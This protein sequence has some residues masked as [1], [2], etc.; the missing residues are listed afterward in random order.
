MLHKKN[1]PLVTIAIPN[2]NMGK[3]IGGAIESALS[4]TFTDFELLIV[5][6]VSTDNSWD[7]IKHYKK[8]DSRIVAVNLDRHIPLP[9]KNWNKCL[10]IARGK[11]IVFLHADDILKPDF[12]K[13]NLEVFDSNPDLGYVFAEKEYIDDQGNVYP[14]HVFY[15]DSGIIP[16]MEEARV[17]LLGWH[18]APVQML[19]RT[20]CMREVGGYEFSD[21]LPVLLLNFGWDVGYRKEILVQ[22]RRHEASASSISIKDKTLIQVLYL[23]K[24][25]ALNLFLPP[26][27]ERLEELK[28]EIKK[29]TAMACLKAYCMDVLGRNENSLCREYMHLARGFW[30]GV[31]D[32]PLYQFLEKAC[33]K[34]DWTPE[35]LNKAWSAIAPPTP[36]TAPP[37]PLPEGSRP[38]TA[39]NISRQAPVDAII[40]PMP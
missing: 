25:M 40:P 5:N 35:A 13:L 32:N 23:T 18:T 29:N 36:G 28:P 24:M 22:Y 38:F 7:I 27:T 37:Y 16:G 17:N 3:Y 6:N 39:K 19:I 33:L 10:D 9:I 21:C 1:T 11:Y 14:S 30:E 34:C 31:C 8:M 2:Y 26:G 4:Q 20:E 12:L 15:K